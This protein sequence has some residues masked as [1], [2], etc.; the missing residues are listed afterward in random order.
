LSLI[1]L[2]NGNLVSCS[3]DNTIKM[4]DIE[5]CECIQ[6]LTGH[7]NTI[8]ELLILKN[9]NIISGSDDKTIEIWE[10]I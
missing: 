6:T 5:T 8:Y 7:T 1:E 9:G 2:R 10:R 4:W 3:F